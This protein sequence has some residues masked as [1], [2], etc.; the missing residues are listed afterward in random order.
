MAVDFERYLKIANIPIKERIVVGYD[1]RE[2][3]SHLY[4][5]FR[6]RTELSLGAGWIY[7]YHR[8]GKKVEAFEFVFDVMKHEGSLWAGSPKCDRVRLERMIKELPV[9]VG[10]IGTD[11]PLYITRY[12]PRK[13]GKKKQERVL[14]P[15]LLEKF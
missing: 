8:Q 5:S 9:R 2:D 3:I 13:R 12:A 1:R 11:K 4:Y 14:Y 15:F 10:L 6:D 7:R